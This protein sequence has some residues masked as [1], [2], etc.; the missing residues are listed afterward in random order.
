MCVTET[1]ITSCFTP[2]GLRYAEYT[3][4]HI[5]PLESLNTAFNKTRSEA[6]FGFHC[7]CSV[8]PWLLN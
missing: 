4:T 8:L 2:L 3:Y 1:H 5:K 6:C 7:L